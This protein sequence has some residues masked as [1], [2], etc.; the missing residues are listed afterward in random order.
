MS[1]LRAAYSLRLSHR[2]CVAEEARAYHKIVTDV[3]LWGVPKGTVING[4]QRKYPGSGLRTPRALH[5]LKKQPGLHLL[6]CTVRV[7]GTD[8]LIDPD[9]A[10]TV[11]L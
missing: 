9:V 7:R 4:D 10:V 2:A 8:W 1:I 11:K 6:Y 3:D 5:P